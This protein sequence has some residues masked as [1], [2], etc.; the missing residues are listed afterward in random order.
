MLAAAELKLQAA[1]P[2]ELREQGRRIRERF[3]LDAPGWYREADEAPYLPAVAAAVWQRQALQVRYRR[4]QAP[5]VVQRRLEPYGIVLKAG[6]WYT[7][8]AGEGR[9]PRTYR[10]G[11]IL[12]LEQF[13][14]R[15]TPAAGFD[16]ARHWQEHTARLQ[17]RLWQG[18]AEIRISPAGVTRLEDFA[19]QAVI[20]GVR[21]GT[22]ESGGWRRAVIPIEDLDHA[23]SELLRLGPE[24]EI[25][26][27]CALRD[28][29]AA[30]IR[31]TATLYG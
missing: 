20:D 15:F 22:P 30:T 14:E 24:V 28:R 31:A 25:L 1:L 2:V 12:S 16:P 9:E 13:E 7:V 26:T 29:I 19:A 17:E 21:R 3:L 23:V 18:E 27:P 11:Q 5:Q 6:R 10:I 8:A 4:W